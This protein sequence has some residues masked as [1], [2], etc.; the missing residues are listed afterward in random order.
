MNIK[1]QHNSV[2]VRTRKLGE[3]NEKVHKKDQHNIFHMTPFVMMKQYVAAVQNPL[4]LG[5]SS[6]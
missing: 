3:R 4:F 2:I 1:V 5:R 6:G